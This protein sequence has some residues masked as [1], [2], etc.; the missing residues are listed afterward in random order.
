MI[1]GLEDFL[2][3]ERKRYLQE[4]KLTPEQLDKL[5]TFR[6]RIEKLISK[7]VKLRT[8]ITDDDHRGDLVSHVYETTY[9][10]I[11]KKKD[12]IVMIDDSIV[13]GTTL[14]RSILRMLDRLE[15]KKIIIVSSAPQIRYPD[16]YGI[17]MSKLKDFVAFR[18]MRAL[19]EERGLDS[20]LDETYERC[21]AAIDKGKAHKHNF[22]K[23]LFEPF[24]DK[25]IS[26]KISK[27][28]TPSE[29]SAEVSIIYQTVEDL[30]KACPNH[31][32]DWYFTGDYPTPGGNRVVNKAFVNFMKGVG[33]RAY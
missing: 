7:D 21:V 3:D 27:I 20:L 24:T 2:A 16:C 13:R 18:A 23:A 31:T 26:Q 10:V 6:P 30:H 8:F 15:P 1:E 32:G 22:V 5:L 28:V 17:D 14:E 19:L 11:N 33:V 4:G 25:E 29:L 12:N 9:E